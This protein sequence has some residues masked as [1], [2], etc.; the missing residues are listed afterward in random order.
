[1][2]ISVVVPV[3]GCK[4]ALRQLYER[5]VRAVSQLTDDFELVLVNDH[6]PQNSWEVIEELCKTDKRVVG[7]NLSRNFGQIKALTAGLDYCSG[8]WVVVMDCDLQDRPEEIINLYNKA[9]E[10]YDVVF[11]RR[12]ERQDS[13]MKKAVSAVFYKINDYFSDGNYDP[14]VC[15]FS[16][17]KKIVIDNYCKLREQNR[18]FVIFIMRMGFNVTSIDVVHD[19]R[20]EGKS[21]YNFKRRFK[22]ASEII[23][24][25]SNKP[26]LLSI[27]LGVLISTLSFLFIVF[28]IIKYFVTK[29]MLSGWTSLI[30]SIYFIGGLLMI[31]LGVIGV[32]I[33]NIFNETK[34]RPL[35]IIRDILNGNDSKKEEMEV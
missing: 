8:D 32:Y 15:N 20:A 34:H 16:I 26:L 22:L 7:I 25:Q 31:N 33:G 27:R 13:F 3:Y 35:Y 14:S 11:A 30:A 10:G 9:M 6:C 1:M 12:K 23:L 5:T 4:A 2:K 24:S 29:E 17:S 28:L 21:S 18:A 19:K